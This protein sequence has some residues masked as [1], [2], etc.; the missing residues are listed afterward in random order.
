MQIFWFSVLLL[1][2]TITGFDIG[3]LFSFFDTKSACD[4]PFA[5]APSI[6]GSLRKIWRGFWSC[7]YEPS[8][9]PG[10]TIDNF[11]RYF[12]IEN[13]QPQYTQGSTVEIGKL[14]NKN[15]S[16]FIITHGFNDGVR[17]GGSYWR[18]FFSLLI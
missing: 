9:N 3:S 12:Y 18:Y 15:N 5:T 14:I 16:N 6:E 13:G 11:I 4:A 17:I 10:Q 8:A 2:P 7:P 1:V